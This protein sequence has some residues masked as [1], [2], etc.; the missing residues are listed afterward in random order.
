MV[1]LFAV[2]GVAWMS[3]TFFGAHLV[4]LEGVLAGVVAEAP[5]MYALVLFVVSK[6]VNSQAA[7]ITAIVPVG[8]HLGVD[9]VAIVGFIGAGYGYFILPTYPSDLAAIGFDPRG[10]RTSA[11]S[12]STTAS[13]CR[14]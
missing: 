8:L 11:G 9:P 10:P 7:A 4:A 1:A 14:A 5:W 6:L 2:F 3:E 12:S 13:S